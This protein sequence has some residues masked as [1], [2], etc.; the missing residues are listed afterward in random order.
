MP[1]TATAVVMSVAI[2]GVPPAPT[3][4]VFLHSKPSRPIANMMRAPIITMAF[5]IGGSETSDSTVM[6]C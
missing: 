4:A 3:A 1:T 2:A 5:S 6:I